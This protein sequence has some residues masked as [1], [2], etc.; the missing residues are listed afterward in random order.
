M[1]LRVKDKTCD[2]VLGHSGQLVGE[3]ILQ[4]N[5]PQHG[6]LGYLLGQ[7][8]PNYVELYVTLSLFQ[9]KL[10]TIT[11]KVQHRKHNCNLCTEMEENCYLK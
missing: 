10:K 11:S 6:L 7:G 8:V 4:T 5:Q 2:V 1:N 9:L 3:H